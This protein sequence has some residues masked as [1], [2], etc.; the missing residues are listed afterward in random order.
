MAQINFNTIFL[1]LF[2]MC[3]F[4]LGVANFV[5]MKN[6]QNKLTG[7]GYHAI[8]FIGF[9]VGLALYKMMNP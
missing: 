2:V 8:L 5:E 3:L 1:I 4:A 7:R 9:G 6:N